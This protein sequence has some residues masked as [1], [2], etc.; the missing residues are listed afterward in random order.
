MGK[1]ELIKWFAN[2]LYNCYHYKL[3]NDDILWVYDPV[4]V[5]KKKLG[6]LL[7]KEVELPPYDE[8]K[9]VFYQDQKNKLLYCSYAE[10]W[11]FLYDNYSPNYGDVELFIKNSLEMILNLNEYTLYWDTNY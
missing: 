11:S 2:I 7:N 4:Y 3:D 1:E 10:I 6:I 5:R 9:V 8:N